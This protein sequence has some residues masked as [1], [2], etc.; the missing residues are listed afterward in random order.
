[1]INDNQKYFV[2]RPSDTSA[3]FCKIRRP[4]HDLIHLF[5]GF[6]HCKSA[7][8]IPINLS[9][10]SLCTAGCI[11]ENCSLVILK[12]QLSSL[13]SESPRWFKNAPISC[14]ATNSGPYQ[15]DNLP[16]I[17]AVLPHSTTISA[18]CHGTCSSKGSTRI[19]MLSSLPEQDQPEA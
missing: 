18:K 11:S 9:S 1:M 10:E 6:S 15:T 5:M 4:P 13:E 16:H 17:S 7:N 19:C 14:T 2:P 3:C 12:T 8:C